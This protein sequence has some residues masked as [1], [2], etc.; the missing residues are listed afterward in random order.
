[1]RGWI[2]ISSYLFEVSVSH[3]KP[4]H[5]QTDWNT[6]QSSKKCWGRLKIIRWEEPQNEKYRNNLHG[7]TKS[8]SAN[9]QEFVPSA[10]PDHVASRPGTAEVQLI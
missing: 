4:V 2:F 1:L 10:E 6:F 9:H 3:T 5:I 7:D 8:R